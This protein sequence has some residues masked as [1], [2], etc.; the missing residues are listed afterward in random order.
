MACRRRDFK[1]YFLLNVGR[2]SKSVRF[3]GW[4]GGEEEEGGERG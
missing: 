1:L 2:N 4:R 3:S